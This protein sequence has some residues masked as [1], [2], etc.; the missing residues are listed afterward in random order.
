MLLMLAIQF[1]TDAVWMGAFGKFFFIGAVTTVL[2]FTLTWALR[3]IP[4]V[5]K[6]I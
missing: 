4:G 2:A 5:K 3:L 1:A 6:V